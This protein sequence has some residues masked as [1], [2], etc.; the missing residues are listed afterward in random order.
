MKYIISF[1]LI[2]Y[3]IFTLF[4]ACGEALESPTDAVAS[5]V[6]S[7]VNKEV[8]V[9][10]NSAV[11][12]QEEAV[13]SKEE[14]QEEPAQTV[15]SK[16]PAPSGSSKAS[17]SSAPSKTPSKPVVSQ[18]PSVSKPAQ[19]TDAPVADIIVEYPT[20]TGESSLKNWLIGNHSDYFADKRNDMLSTMGNKGNVTYYRPSIPTNHSL[21]TLSQVEVHTPS[22]GMNYFYNG[23]GEESELVVLVNNRDA[24]AQGFGKI[25]A[26][27]YAQ[28][29]SYC[30]ENAL[31]LPEGSVAKHV[32]FSDMDFY[33]QY[34]SNRDNTT[35]VWQQFGLYQ[36]ATLQGHFD[37]I[38]EIIP[39]LYLQ[40]VTV[41]NSAV[42]K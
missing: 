27:R 28:I 34:N 15:S 38:E 10:E 16:T 4:T 41:D 14:P 31:K 20:F 7:V 17:V 8:A 3:L 37:Q 2:L 35:I 32:S 23:I 42:M 1:I 29:K 40:K 30:L 36:T 33:C 19:N 25:E 22:G 9:D 24:T 11:S 39:L 21:F 12:Q 26:N 6:E 18:T 5:V 13:V